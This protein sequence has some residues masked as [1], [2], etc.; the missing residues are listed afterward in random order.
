MARSISKVPE[1]L[2]GRVACAAT[3]QCVQDALYV[4]GGKW[5]LPLILCLMEAPMRFNEL[6]A[7]ISGLSA[8]VLAKEL[9]DLEL[10]EFITRTV[11]PGSPAVVRYTATPYSHTLKDVLRTLGD[12][13]AQH[14]A[15]IRKSLRGAA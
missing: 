12:W 15:L 2:P 8:K 13:G 9:K 3:L 4:I 1:A 10:N 14:R 5:K 7:H 11:T 6:Q